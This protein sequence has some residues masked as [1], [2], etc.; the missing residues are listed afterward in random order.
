LSVKG[1]DVT[2]ERTLADLLAR[3]TELADDVQPPVADLLR[4]G[5]RRRSQR[6]G[7]RAISVAAIAIIAVAAPQAVRT[8]DHHGQPPGPV[9][10]LPGLIPSGSP[11]AASGPTGAQIAGFRWSELPSAPLHTTQPATVAWAGNELLAL[12]GPVNGRPSPDGAAF[13]PATGRWHQIAPAPAGVKLGFATSVWTGSQFF[14]T[15]L[16]SS[17]QG[18]SQGKSPSAC[19]PL[20]GLYDPATNRWSTTA[21]PRSLQDF[22][23]MTATWTGSDVVLAGVSSHYRLE[24]AAYDPAANRWQLITP[25]L[26]AGHSPAYA[27][28]AATARQLI[29]WVMWQHTRSLHNGFSIRSG[30][31]VFALSGNGTWRDMTGRWL[32]HQTMSTPTVTS[33]GL[34]VSPGEIW[35]GDYCSPPSAI[36]PGYFTRPDGWHRTDVPVSPVD[37]AFPAYIWTGRTIIEA[38]GPITEHTTTGLSIRPARLVV[39]DQAASRWRTLPAPPTRFF[40]AAPPVWTGTELLLLTYH[41]HLYALRG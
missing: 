27:T 38:S 1:N 4:R 31:D 28:V 12:G 21:V 33:S 35:C 40:F 10:L 32:Q 18:S 8:L 26:P 25:T 9:A 36:D 3:A 30:I 23:P 39:L 41:D 5:R 7:A 2:D 24:V 17:C 16:R 20:A 22:G 15:D 11:P 14:V 19:G 34:L 6:T 37:A 13:E 29:V